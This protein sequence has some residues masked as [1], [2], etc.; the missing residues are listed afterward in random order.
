LQQATAVA[1]NWE[2]ADAN[3]DFINSGSIGIAATADATDSNVA[4]ALATVSSGIVQEAFASAWTAADAD[5]TFNN[6]GT[7]DIVASAGA[8]AWTSAQAIAAVNDA[9]RQDASAIANAD[10]NATAS[11]VNSGTI[12]I[13]ATA[14]AIWMSDA[15]AS[16]QID[17]G[18]EQDAFA[19]GTNAVADVNLTNSGP[20][21]FG[22]RF[23]RDHRDRSIGDGNRHFCRRCLHLVEQ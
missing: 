4:F 16:A 3:A 7:I 2:T 5:V 14:S 10:A 13:G 8:S 23:R 12:H 6:S 20:G 11:L 15:F 17:T 19:S 9:I 21:G 1:S 22:R 18:I